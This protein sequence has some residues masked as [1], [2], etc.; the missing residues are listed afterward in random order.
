MG[1]GLRELNSEEFEK[2]CSKN[3]SL[4]SPPMLNIEKNVKLNFSTDFSIRV[5]TSGCYFYDNPSGKW[6]SNGMEVGEET[7]MEYTQCYSNHLTQFA[8]GFIVLPNKINFEYVWANAGFLQNQTI[9][10]TVI[11]LTL[12]YILVAIWAYI[13]DK[14][15]KK[16]LGITI[17][18]D[19]S[20]IDSYFY[21]II[22]F[23]GSRR[24][25]ATDSKV[26][27]ICSGELSDTS[28][29]LLN[30]KKRSVFRRGGIDSFIMSVKEP[31]GNLNY[32]RVWHDN[33]GKG[34]MASWYL[35]YI[36][37][38]DLQTRNKFYFLCENWLA[39]EKSDG[40]IDRIL[41][42]AGEKQKSEI[43]YLIKKQAKQ[44]MSDGHLWFSIFA[45]PAQSSFT[46]LDRVT[47][48]FVVLCITMLIN[49]LYYG[50]DTAVHSGGLEIGPFKLTAEQ[51][52]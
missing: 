48:C 12:A 36:V 17:L 2:Y 43:R 14:R 19:N 1:F 37:V 28:V 15:D 8:G 4:N 27:V 29:R 10:F 39:V 31:L 22:V 44:N 7:N 5:F 52:I 26:R 18:E 51:V 11:G 25:A 9:Y 50:L 6:T 23:T 38:H 49:I 30:D 35:K 3:I 45:R 33:S 16:R 41:P 13:N 46:R 20:S 40:V 42:V 32:I 34:N 24:E 21:E 47:C